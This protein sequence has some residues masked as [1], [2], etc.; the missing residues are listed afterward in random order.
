[1]IDTR[2]AALVGDG[3]WTVLCRW[4]LGLGLC[5]LLIVNQYAALPRILN[6]DEV[7]YVMAARHGVL[8]NYVEHGSIDFIQF[9]ALARA[10]AKAFTKLS[11]PASRSAGAPL[12]TL[13]L[14]PTR[15]EK[16]PSG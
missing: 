4:A 7:D 1:M 9:I 2:A 8:D 3:R 16:S 6:F 13:R 5:G 15:R 12:I 11:R 14:K 10:K